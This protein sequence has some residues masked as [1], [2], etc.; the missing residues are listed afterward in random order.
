LQTSLSTVPLPNTVF[1]TTRTFDLRQKIENIQSTEG[2]LGDTTG[3]GAA[4]EDPL[5]GGTRVVGGKAGYIGL[6]SGSENK[7]QVPDGGDFQGASLFLHSDVL[8]MFPLC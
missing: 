5:W 8:I 2:F 6:P 4:V 3:E 7:R 1:Y